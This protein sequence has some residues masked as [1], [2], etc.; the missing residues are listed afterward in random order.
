MVPSQSCL[1]TLPFDITTYSFMF[2]NKCFY[3]ICSL[4]SHII[5]FY[6]IKNHYFIF[7]KF[8]WP[9]LL[10]ALSG[11][12][13]KMYYMYIINPFLGIELDP[14]LLVMQH[15]TVTIIIM[16][17]AQCCIISVVD[18]VGNPL[19]HYRSRI[20]CMKCFY[21]SSNFQFRDVISLA[22][23]TTILWV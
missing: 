9:Q 23:S 11:S 18:R 19:S 12:N 7:K 3:Y 2:Y 15:W 6:I 10:A 17:P 13:T 22:V 16:F 5:L 8:F 4:A 14:V 1:C 21:T 20:S